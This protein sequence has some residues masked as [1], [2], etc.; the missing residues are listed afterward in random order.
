MNP[1]FSGI[2]FVS[3]SWY[4]IIPQYRI[5]LFYIHWVLSSFSVSGTQ[6]SLCSKDVPLFNL[7]PTPKVYSGLINNRIN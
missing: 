3:S 5:N 7:F 6:T 2:L 1:E 4:F